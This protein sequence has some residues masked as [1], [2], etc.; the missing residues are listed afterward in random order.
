MLDYKTTTF[1]TLCEQMN[2][3]KTAEIL[4]MT[5]PAVTQHI[6]AL[7]ESYG[8]LLFLYD[9]RALTKTPQA[10]MLEQHLRKV[11]YDEAHLKAQL[12]KSCVPDLRLGATKS[13]GDYMI[14]EKMIA[15]VSSRQYRVHLLVDNT[16]ALLQHIQHGTIDIAMVEGE[17]DKHMFGAT[18]MQTEEY[19]GICAK[20]C[21]LAGREVTFEEAA[22]YH[23]MIQEDGSGTRTIFENQLK[24]HG[25]SLSSFADS[26]YISS[27]VVI[28]ELVATG[29]GITFRYRSV[30]SRDP[31][32]AFFHI[33]G[34]PRTH[35]LY[36]VYLKDS[37]AENWIAALLSL[38]TIS[39]ADHSAGNVSNTAEEM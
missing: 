31:R 2:C 34:F 3:R 16:K 21:P 27:F 30:A 5:Q 24:S 29:L 22:G 37:H 35:D 12:Q 28:K 9:H 8:C 13:I 23:L 4:H 1:L 32:L 15:L 10:K 20:N 7:E 14:A 33:Q 38:D 26:A 36:Y 39:R 6:H 19:L 18:L 11:R 17:F 25:K